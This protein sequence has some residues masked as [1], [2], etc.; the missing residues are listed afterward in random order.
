MDRHYSSDGCLFSRIIMTEE[1][2][3]PFQTYVLKIK[4]QLVGGIFVRVDNTW[5]GK[6]YLFQIEVTTHDTDAGVSWSNKKI[7][8]LKLKDIID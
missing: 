7:F 2:L 6:R 4:D 5:F 3:I 8:K 1:K